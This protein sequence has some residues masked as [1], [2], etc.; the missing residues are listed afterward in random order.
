M[1]HYRAMAELLS[2]RA[3]N[4]ALLARQLLLE[5]HA[6]T[7]ERAMEHLVGMQAQVPTDPYIGLWTRL[8]GFRAD[9]LAGLIERRRAVRATTMLRTTIHLFS[10]RDALA[11]RPVLQ[12]MVE[13]QFRYSPFARAI[14]GV[15]VP[16]VLEEGRSLLAG[17]PMTISELGKRLAERWPQAEP[18]PLAYAVRYLVPLVQVPPRGLWGRSGLPRVAL[19][20]AWLADVPSVAATPDDLVL[21]YL[22]AFGPATAADVQVWCWLTGIRPILEGLRPRLRTFRDEAGRELFDVADGPLPDP[23]TPAPIRLLPEYDNI[24]LSH[25]DRSRVVGSLRDASPLWKGFVLVDGFLMGTWK[26]ERGDGV[27]TLRVSRYGPIARHDRAS[28]REEGD[29]LLGFTDEGTRASR[30]RIE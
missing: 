17:A 16:E 6:L 7:A 3:L 22:A 11:V 23:E 26:V 1:P 12:P 10:A 8:E 5:R 21:R 28:L 9:E 24:L 30:I 27:A 2:R 29:R 13:R 4:R 14:A 19:T 25:K 18:A 20:E 15:P